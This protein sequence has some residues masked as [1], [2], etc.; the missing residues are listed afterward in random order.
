MLKLID[1][2]VGVGFISLLMWAVVPNLPAENTP[3]QYYNQYISSYIEK[4]AQKDKQ[5]SGSC[6][7][8]I[9]RYGALN[10]LKAAYAAYFHKE[11]VAQMMIT[12]VEKKDY[13]V[14]RFINSSFFE[15]Y[16]ASAEEL[17]QKLNDSNK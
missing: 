2:T 15:V 7:P 13:K 3:E 5:F 9:K 12:K 17:K 4:C 10:C 1:I 16:R 8:S 6:M 14:E 11:L